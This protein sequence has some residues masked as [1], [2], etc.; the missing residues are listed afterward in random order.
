M[1]PLA[2]IGFYSFGT[3]SL[4]TFGTPFGWTLG[5]YSSL[6]SSFYLGTIE[7]SVVLSLSATLACAILAVPIAF[8]IVR[9]RGRLQTLLLLA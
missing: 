9:Q 6:H 7:R 2:L 5:N 3:T 8:F 4:V 1:A